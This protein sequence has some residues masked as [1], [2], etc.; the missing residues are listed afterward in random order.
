MDHLDF[1]EEFSMA[2]CLPIA[3]L[4]FFIKLLS[5]LFKVWPIALKTCER[6]KR[7]ASEITSFRVLIQATAEM[8]RGP[9]A[10]S[11]A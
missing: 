7:D 8:F 4:F 5:K 6:Y 2:L 9:S 1:V 11:S 3:D 10:A